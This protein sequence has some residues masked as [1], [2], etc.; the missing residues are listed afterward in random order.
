[1]KD[2]IRTKYHCA[3]MH[4]NLLYNKKLFLM[5][6]SM[7]NEIN[8]NQIP[9][10]DDNEPLIDLKNQQHLLFGSPPDTPLTYIDYTKMRK[11][12]YEKL[13]IAQN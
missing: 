4:K 12:V 9:F 2:K 13:L 10:N 8:I 11:S 7:L 6:K 5:N 3:V 1:M